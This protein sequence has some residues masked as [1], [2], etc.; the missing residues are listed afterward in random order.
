MVNLT[1]AQVAVLKRVLGI[2]NR[3]EDLV[4]DREQ[5]RPMSRELVD[6][7]DLIAH[8]GPPIHA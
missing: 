5:Q 1:P 2:G 7:G 8:L 3:T 4:C 6:G